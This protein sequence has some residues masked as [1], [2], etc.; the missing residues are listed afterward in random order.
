LKHQTIW[1]WVK[2]GTVA[3]RIHKL[4]KF[5]IAM[6]RPKLQQVIMVEMWDMRLPRA[7]ASRN[8]ADFLGL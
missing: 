5:R 7:I 2:S 6:E 1:G 8:A 4:G 3:R